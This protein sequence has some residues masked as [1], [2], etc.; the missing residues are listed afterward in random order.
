MLAPI[1]TEMNLIVRDKPGLLKFLTE[2]AEV[3]TS[4]IAF[5]YYGK[6]EDATFYVRIEQRE[7]SSGIVTR[8]VTAKG[9]FVSDDGINQ[10]KEVTL[11]I[12]EDA[13]DDYKAF[14]EVVGLKPRD[15]KT[16]TRHAF[17]INDLDVTLDE[18]DTSELGDRLE[19]EGSDIT[20]I[21]EFASKLKQFCDDTPSE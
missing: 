15:I 6:P 10:R 13:D 12:P 3:R 7:D 19:I 21:Q 5:N 17:K 18:W 8:F 2:L 9:S 14:L 16:K 4:R 20:A 11:T 1:E